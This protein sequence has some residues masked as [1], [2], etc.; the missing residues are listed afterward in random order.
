MS[1]TGQAREAFSGKHSCDQAVK[2][3]IKEL[4]KFYLKVNQYSAYEVYQQV[5]KFCRSKLVSISNHI[6]EF[7]CLYDKIKNF[8]MVSPAGVL[9]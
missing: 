6:I 3:L 1:L 5:Q 2:N 4:D 8:N 9:A 7:E